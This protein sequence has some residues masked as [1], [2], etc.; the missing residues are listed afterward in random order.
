MNTGHEGSMS[1]V[2]SNNPPG[3]ITRLSGLVKQKGLGYTDESV[4]TLIG[5]AIDVIIQITR[6]RSGT[7]KIEYITLVDMEKEG[8]IIL[9][10][11]YRFK[12]GKG[13]GKDQDNGE[14]IRTEE[15]LTDRIYNKL[16]DAGIDPTGFD[17]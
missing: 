17:R 9:K 10:D 14:F 2:H 7:R 8:E 13:S 11:I 4:K 1:T 5:Q 15:K 3:C 16:V 6:T 12:R